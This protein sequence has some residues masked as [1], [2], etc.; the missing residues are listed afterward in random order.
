MSV[1]HSIVHSSPGTSPGTSSGTFYLCIQ[2]ISG[3]FSCQKKDSPV[4]PVNTPPS[5]LVSVPSFIPPFL[6]KS[7]IWVSL[8]P[9]LPKIY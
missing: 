9:S 4:S 3:N 2:S 1:T 8:A 5:R 7:Y 6:H